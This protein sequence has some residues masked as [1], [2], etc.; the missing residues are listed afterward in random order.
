MSADTNSSFVH[1]TCPECGC[2]LISRNYY[3]EYTHG[4]EGPVT[5]SLNGKVCKKI[6][7]AMV[8]IITDLQLDKELAEEAA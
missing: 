8:D 6:T 7:E 2:E 3:M 1:M 4:M 5:T